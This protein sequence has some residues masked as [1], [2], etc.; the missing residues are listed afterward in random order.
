[1]KRIFYNP[2]SVRDPNCTNIVAAVAEFPPEGF[3]EAD[4]S[5]LEGLEKL[6]VQGEVTY[7]GRL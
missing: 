1:M 6:Y 3:V 7:Y 5:V 2:T 4:P